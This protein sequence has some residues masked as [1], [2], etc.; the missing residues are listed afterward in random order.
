MGKMTVVI[1]DKL[2]QAAIEVMGK[3]QKR[4]YRGGTKRTCT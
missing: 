4:S 2:L 3:K 1:D